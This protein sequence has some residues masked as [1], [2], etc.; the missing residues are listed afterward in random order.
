MTR[1]EQWI[2]FY[3]AALAGNCADQNQSSADSDKN[4]AK[5]ADLAMA[6]LDALAFPKPKIAALLEAANAVWGSAVTASNG[7]LVRNDL[8]AALGKAVTDFEEQS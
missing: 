8:M 1:R 7:R 3:T 5:S 4:A 6:R 2:S